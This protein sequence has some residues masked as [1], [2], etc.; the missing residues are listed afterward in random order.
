[1]HLQFRERAQ[2][3]FLSL[4]IVLLIT[5]A[6]GLYSLQS[7]ADSE[8][9]TGTVT[10]IQF[11]EP[12]NSFK[13]SST[14]GAGVDGHEIGDTA[15]IYT[16]S[17][18]KAMKSAGFG[19]LSYRL[20]TELGVEAWHWNPS[21][22][23]SNPT[24][25]QGYWISDT[26]LS[27]PIHHSFG[28]RL[29]HRG[30]TID[31]A[32]NDGFSR[33]DDGDP[34][35]YW[36]SNPYLDS[37]F[38]GE[39]NERHPQWVVIDLGNPTPINAIKINWGALAAESYQVEY[40]INQTPRDIEDEVPTDWAP[41]PQGAVTKVNRTGIVDTIAP[42]P[43]MARYVRI[44]FTSGGRQIQ[45][46]RDVR[47]QV[48]ISINEI[49]LGQKNDQ[50]VFTDEI[51]HSNDHTKQTPIYVS[52]TDPWHQASDKDSGTEQP[53]FDLVYKSGLTNNQP[54]LLPVG[55]LYDT[56][57][58]AVAEV[59]YLRAR[60]YPVTHIEMGEEPDGQYITPEDYGAL[61]IQWA[62]ALHA[63]DPSLQLGGPCFQTTISEYSTW[64]IGN[65]R[66][67]WM[68]RFLSYLSEH[69]H[70][71]DYTFF[72]F[73]WYP[74]D[75]GCV[76]AQQHLI[77]HPSILKGV[78][79]R[80]QRDG[81]TKDIP[82]MI[83]EY[84]YSA[85]SCKS[86]VDLEGAIFN[87][88]TV[89]LFLSLGGSRVYLYG[90]EPATL[91]DELTCNSWGN[92]ALFVSNDSDGI[93]FPTATFYGA[94]LLNDHWVTPGEGLH[95]L[96]G[97]ESTV[98]DTNGMEVITAYPLK[99]P[100]GSWSILLLNKDKY[101]SY[102][103]SLQEK[104]SASNNVKPLIGAKDIYQ[105]STQ[106]FQWH[107]NKKDGYAAPNSPPLEF[108]SSTDKIELPAFSLTVVH[109]AANTQQ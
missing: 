54:M 63:Y 71:K 3:L 53:G 95:Q 20:R 55:L 62:N 98:K 58:N 91:A 41:F 19:P 26:K 80:L 82:W 68:A 51:I 11:D 31:Q 72:S 16:D 67:T 102:S 32:N 70:Q 64:P 100:D 13:P 65:D 7:F 42:T 14:L 50:G 74:F 39:P 92:N 77:Q 48:G 43:I 61:Y 78:L 17:N 21:G 35:S 47:E 59:V 9:R 84:G 81:L 23:W 96:H 104:N 29:P 52:S 49:Q 44:L 22:T 28:Y 18:L 76:D 25:K 37:Y 86:E 4:L 83:T 57:E 109:L 40:I 88:E 103:V 79:A 27:K 66:R 97:A 10:V 5:F 99:F 15:A 101:N 12:L 2:K 107:A 36:K 108:K 38:T 1:M 94:K 6:G 24:K 45:P 60:G 75:N 89:A 90:F 30:S 34:R 46:H 8:A 56:P 85:F 106:Q 93:K 69:G 73:E 33:L 105:Y 87:A